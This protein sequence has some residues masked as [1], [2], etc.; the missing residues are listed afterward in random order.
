MGFNSAFKGLM[1]CTKL[2]CQ[3]HI[4]NFLADPSC[5]AFEISLAECNADTTKK[6][7]FAVNTTIDLKKYNKHIQ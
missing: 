3:S 1:K 4:P 6:I 2:A 7:T 5:P